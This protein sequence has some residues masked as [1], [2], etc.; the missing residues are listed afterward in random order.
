MDDLKKKIFFI[1]SNQTKLDKLIEY[2]IQRNRGI[3]DLKAGN[4]NSEFIKEIKYENSTF[5]VYINSF[6]ISH[7]NLKT[8]DID[9]KTK[10]TQYQLL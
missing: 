3:I 8:K 7:K 10:N 4:F 5:S 1:T 6:E 2:Q 9:R